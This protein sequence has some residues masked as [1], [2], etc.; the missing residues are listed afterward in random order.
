[1]TADQLTPKQRF[2]RGSRPYGY[3]VLRPLG[4]LCVPTAL[5]LGVTPNQVTLATLPIILAAMGF[6]AAGGVALSVSGI[7]ILHIG[8]VLDHLDG[9]LARA[10][11]KTSTR[12]EFLDALI[13]YIY[14]ALL[15]PA[16]GYGLSRVPDLG[17]DAIREIVDIPA[18]AY[19]QIG[20]WAGLAFVTSRLIS[21]RFR[22]M[23]AQSLRERAAGFGRASMIFSSTLPLIFIVGAVTQFLSVV[24]IVYAAFYALTLTYIIAGSYVRSGS[25]PDA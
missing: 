16:V 14:G 5:K 10:T 21:L 9:E 18:D 1:M 2:E 3:F 23:F 24:L 25:Q 20:L 22:S 7:L 19:L 13:G 8:L 15:P 11:G 17:H 4:K 12:G 6:L